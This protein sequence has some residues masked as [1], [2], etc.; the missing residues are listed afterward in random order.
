MMRVICSAWQTRGIP[1]NYE[2]IDFTF[3][4]NLPVDMLYLGDV[5]GKLKGI[6]SDE[7]LL[8]ML[9]FVSDVK[10][11]L[12]LIEQERYDS[13]SGMLAQVQDIEDVV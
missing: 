7:T 3:N 5:A 1:L 13:G 2:D 8:G 6:V 11:E 12:E 10:R 9:P 4:R